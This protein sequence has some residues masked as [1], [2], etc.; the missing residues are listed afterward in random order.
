MQTPADLLKNFVLARSLA[1]AE[2]TT[3]VAVKSDWKG[4]YALNKVA[5][6]SQWQMASGF[7]SHGYFLRVCGDFGH[8]TSGYRHELQADCLP[9]S[10]R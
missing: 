1:T 6:S 3:P 8:A 2:N 10:D 4:A 7:A 5:P 9:S